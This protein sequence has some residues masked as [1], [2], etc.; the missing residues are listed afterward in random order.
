[1]AFHPTLINPLAFITDMVTLSRGLK[2][3]IPFLAPQ[4]T[5]PVSWGFSVSMKS[6]S[7]ASVFTTDAFFDGEKG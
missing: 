5:Y 7:L 3:W 4:F 1:M 2:R 6:M